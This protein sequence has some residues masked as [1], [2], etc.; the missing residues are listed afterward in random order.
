MKLGKLQLNKT[1]KIGGLQSLQGEMKTGD[2][3]T[4]IH[5]LYKSN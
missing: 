5:V 4:R 3:Q 1:T 2:N